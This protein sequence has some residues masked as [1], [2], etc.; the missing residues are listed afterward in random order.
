MEGRIS[1]TARP[2][3][4]R[5]SARGRRTNRRTPEPRAGS[6]PGD[7][8]PRSDGVRSGLK[9]PTRHG[10]PDG[11]RPR[12][13]RLAA[14]P[15]RRYAHGPRGASPEHRHLNRRS[16]SPTGSRWVVSYRS[17]PAPL[18]PMV[19]PGNALRPDGD[20]RSRNRKKAL[21]V[22][23]AAPRAFNGTFAARVDLILD[24]PVGPS[25]RPCLTSLARHRSRSRARKNRWQEQD[26]HDV[27]ISEVKESPA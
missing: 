27:P 6:S 15:A 20:L 16:L 26:L 4:L 22:R 24:G 25:R 21:A 12:K 1:A 13:Q 10:V 2:R 14:A 19:P 9:R 17:T 11:Y 23:K 5:K 7:S 3:R 18:R 8:A